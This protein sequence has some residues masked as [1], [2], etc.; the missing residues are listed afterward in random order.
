[1]IQVTR[2]LSSG[3]SPRDIINTTEHLN[4]RR[5][6]SGNWSGDRNSASSS[7]STTTDNPYLYIINKMQKNT[8]IPKSPT[9]KSGELSSSSSGH[10]DAGYDSYS[11]SSTDSLPL[12]QI[13]KHNLQV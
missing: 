1:M 13:L 6:D 3:S 8:G 4:I 7:S 10:Y 11:L 12:Q 5:R 2:S 9:C